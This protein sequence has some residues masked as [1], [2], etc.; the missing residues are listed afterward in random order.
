MVREDIP[1]TPRWVKLFGILAL[2]VLLAV[3]IVHLTGG[4]FHGHSLHE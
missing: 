3:L 4:G 2:L 1:V